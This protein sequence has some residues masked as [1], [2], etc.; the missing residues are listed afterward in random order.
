MVH[1]EPTFFHCVPQ[2]RGGV[3]RRAIRRRVLPS[4]STVDVHGQQSQDPHKLR[5]RSWS[6]S[7]QPRTAL[8]PTSDVGELGQAGLL[9]RRGLGQGGQCSQLPRHDPHLCSALLPHSR[10]QL[11]HRQGRL[12][13]GQCEDV[14][15]GPGIDQ[16]LATGCPSGSGHKDAARRQQRLFLFQ[17]AGLRY[18]RLRLSAG[19]TVYCI[20][21]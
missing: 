20:I 6:G 11:S 8:F 15:E 3:H 10:A 2:V 7:L 9:H 21:Y 4:A 17:P 13:R 18:A 16:G 12:A 19:E 1:K 14:A 5:H